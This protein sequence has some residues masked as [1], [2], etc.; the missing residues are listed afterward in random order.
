MKLTTL[1][2]ALLVTGLLSPVSQAADWSDT[3]LSYRYGTKFAEPF[4]NQDISKNI[5]GFTDVRGFSSGVS[6]LNVDYLLSDSKDPQSL[7]SS[8]GAQEVYLVYRYTIDLS[9]ILNKTIRFGAIKS[10]GPT[11]GF[12]LNSKHDVGYNSRKQMIV[13]GPTLGW[14]VPSGHLNTGILIL[15]ES[16]APSGPFPP[17]STVKGRYTYKTHPMLAIDWSLPV[18]SLPLAFEGYANFIASKG[19]DEVGNETG[20][21]TNIDMQ[22]M[23]DVGRSMGGA[24]NTFKLG[25]EYQ[26]WKNKFGNTTATAGSGSFARTPMIRGEYHF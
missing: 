11:L 20:A 24:K 15:R 12:D 26:Y 16:N 18:G 3:S 22:L 17:I 2:S 14:D 25:V 1:A 7:G 21:E 8:R 19:K 10:M 6:F 23:W 9:K 5:F 13:T 4:N